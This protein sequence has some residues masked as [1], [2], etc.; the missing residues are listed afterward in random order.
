MEYGFF[1][2]VNGDR[3]YNARDIS[4]YFEHIISSGLYKSITNCMK[5]TAAGGM[6][7]YVAPGSGLIDSQW[8]RQEAGS[9]VTIS[10]AHATLPR[11]DSVVVRLDLSDAVRSIVLDVVT[12]TPSAAPVATDPVRLEK[13]KE[14]VL[15][16]VYVGAAA[17]EIT[18]ANITDTRAEEAICGW[19]QSL[20]DAPLLTAVSGVYT[21]TAGATTVVPIAVAGYNPAMDVINV[22]KDGLRLTPGIDYTLDRDTQ[23]ITLAE[24]VKSGTVIAFEALKPVQPD[25]IPDAVEL[26]QDVLN[27]VSG[28]NERITSVETDFDAL[29]TDLELLESKVPTVATYTA[30]IP[31]SGW[32][33]SAAPYSVNATIS[34]ILA[35]DNPVVD[36]VQTGTESTDS[37]MRDAWGVITRITTAAGSITVYASE[38]PSVAIPIQLKV[39]R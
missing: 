25:T 23:Q 1:N 26:M 5:V 17:T 9:S 21:T 19:A 7:L 38:K 18:D 24:S 29:R 30:T 34:G 15:A 31:A 37:A 3:K 36:I 16:H 39:V 8:F 4:R 2:S 11:I 33:G 6:S 28:Y 14:L 35:S 32:A 10:T 22:Y 12:G 27:E 20:V 13:V